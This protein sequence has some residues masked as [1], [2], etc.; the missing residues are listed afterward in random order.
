[1][2]N[3]SIEYTE[4]DRERILPADPFKTSKEDSRDD[5]ERDRARIIHSNAFRRLQGKTQIMSPGDFDFYRTRL[6]HSLEAAQIS[7][8]FARK[9]GF[10][11]NLVEGCALAHDIGHP[12]LGHSG[13]RKLNDLMKEYGF[14]E[15]NAQNI[16]IL[17][18]LEVKVVK[19]NVSYGLNLTRA[20]LDGVIKYKTLIE[21]KDQKGIYKEDEPVLAFIDPLYKD[22]HIPIEAKIMDWADDIAYSVHDIEDGIR[23]GLINV[24]SLKKI[25]DKVF[26]ILSKKA[27]PEKFIKDKLESLIKEVESINLS[28]GFTRKEKT[29]YFT[30]F[31]INKFINLTSIVKT[32]PKR[33]NTQRYS[34]DLKIEE[35]AKLEVLLLRE[36]SKELFIEDYRLEQLKHKLEFIIERLFYVFLENKEKYFPEDFKFLYNYLGADTNEKVRYRLVCDFVSGMTDKYAIKLYRRMF[37]PIHD[38]LF[39]II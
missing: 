21:K 13:E 2:G 9:F 8:S 17:T 36:I 25:Y 18:F 3:L 37:S 1:M 31:R 23:L 33:E 14:F 38:S 4:F 16:R 10:D 27:V 32:D 20:L 5:F 12:P 28:S 24:L 22:G 39:D 11:E 35:E 34:F 30:S 7:K 6:T 26:Y 29:R 15:S 19:E